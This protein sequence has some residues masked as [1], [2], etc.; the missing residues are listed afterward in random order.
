MKE[1]ISTE[2]HILDLYNNKTSV[3]DKTLIMNYLNGAS[4]EI[5][6]SKYFENITESIRNEIIGNDM[7]TKIDAVVMCSIN[8]GKKLCQFNKESRILNVSAEKELKNC[9]AL[10]ILDSLQKSS[11]NNSLIT[12]QLSGDDYSI[13]E[14]KKTFGEVNALYGS[15]RIKTVSEKNVSNYKQ[16]QNSVD[17]EKPSIKNQSFW[18][19][20]SPK[21]KKIFTICII[22]LISL[23][24]IISVVVTGIKDKKEKQATTNNYE[25]NQID[26]NSNENSNYSISETIN[27][28]SDTIAEYEIDSASDFVKGRAWVKYKTKNENGLERVYHALIDKK[29]DIVYSFCENTLKQDTD[30]DGYLK[31][32]VF[33]NCTAAYYAKDEY[34]PNIAPSIGIILIDKDGKVLFQSEDNNDTTDYYFFSYGEGKYLIKKHQADF[35]STNDSVLVLDSNG[36]ITDSITGNFEDAIYIGNNCFILKNF[37]KESGKKSITVY[38]AVSK[39]IVEELP[40]NYDLNPHSKLFYPYF[41]SY[42]EFVVLNSKEYYYMPF[43]IFRS[44]EAYESC[45]ENDGIKVVDKDNL[46]YDGIITEKTSENQ[47]EFYD[48]SGNLLC[49]TPTFPENTYIKECGVF[50]GGYCKLILTGQDKKEYLTVI[51]KKG[52]SIFEP[53][54]I[55]CD[56][57]NCDISTK[58]YKGYALI[59]EHK[60]VTPNGVL[61]E[62]DSLPDEILSYLKGASDGLVCIYK[63]E[64]NTFVSEGKYTYEDLHGNTVISLVRLTTN[65]IVVGGDEIQSTT[66]TASTQAATNAHNYSRVRN[67]SIVGKW[68]SIGSYGFGQAQPG[69][70]VVFDGVN[71]N[72]YSPSDTYAL[73]KSGNDFTLECTNFLFGDTVTF[74][75]KTIDKDHIDIYYGS[76]VTE[77]VR[78]Q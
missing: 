25:S 28:V 10:F 53:V 34:Y 2:N 38:D 33:D 67:F 47:F 66:T 5:I 60:A 56:D 9:F 39:R 51:D 8:I 30:I 46:G 24:V 12:I 49:K 32:E 35:S 52:N 41:N 40:F 58:Q 62:P 18:D 37:L 20:I 36:E 78:V 71:C 43:S 59:C 14:Y 74:T 73:T 50:N 11:L 29:G 54:K 15:E 57:E 27:A 65:S 64:K 69:A 31:T 45:I 77:L 75:V 48:L 17:S 4:N 22:S 63:K 23:L 42:G 16:S 6:S 76:R 21:N 3:A 19:N 13:T 55:E 72:F 61:V 26:Y 7:R 68:K 44:K 70:I 1:V